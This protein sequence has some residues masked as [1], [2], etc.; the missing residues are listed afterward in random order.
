[1]KDRSGTCPKCGSYLLAR[2]S[3]FIFCLESGCNW[4]VQ[5]KRKDDKDI[6]DIQKLKEDWK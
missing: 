5:G 4:A 2:E 1:M 3:K 6:T